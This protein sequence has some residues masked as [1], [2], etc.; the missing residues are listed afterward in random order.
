MSLLAMYG[1]HHTGETLL[2][3]TSHTVIQLESYSVTGIVIFLNFQLDALHIDL[4]D[5]G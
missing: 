3:N 1:G 2:N 5:A 4:Q